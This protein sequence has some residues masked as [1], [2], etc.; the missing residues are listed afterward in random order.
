MRFFQKYRWLWLGL[1][2]L[3]GSFFSPFLPQA[4]QITNAIESWFVEDDPLL[5][6]YQDFQQSFG[7]DEVITVIIHD[8]AGVINRNTLL[9]MQESIG[10]MKEIEGVEEVY[11]LSNAHTFRLSAGRYFTPA[12]PEPLPKTS[13]FY[14]SL[15]NFYQ[16]A[17][18]VTGN[19]VH[20]KGRSLR[21]IVQLGFLS[22]IQ[23]RMDEIVEGVEKALFTHFPERNVS[24]GGSSVIYSGLNSLTQRDFALFLGSGVGLIMLF[25]LVLYR[26]F[27]VVIY[28]LATFFLVLWLA[29]GIY[30]ALGYSLNL[31]SSIAPI[32]LTIVSLLDII[33]ILNHY[34]AQGQKDIIPALKRVWWPCLFTTLTTVAGF[35]SFLFTPLSIL[36]QFGL[37]VGIGLSLALLVSFV[38]AFFFLP[39]ISYEKSSLGIRAE[40]LLLRLFRFSVKKKYAILAF[41]LMTVVGLGYGVSQ[42]NA[43][44]YTLGYFPKE[45]PVIEDHQEILQRWG[46]YFPID[47]M[48]Y[49]E[50]ATQGST[51]V[52]SP[53]LL[54][55]TAE[56]ARRV[57]DIEGITRASGFHELYTRTLPVM[58]GPMWRNRLNSRLV[59]RYT[60]QAL[61]RDSSLVR[62]WLPAGEKKGRLILSGDVVS[63]SELSVMLSQIHALSQEVYGSTADLRPTGYIPLYAGIV[64]Y[65][66]TSQQRSLAIAAGLVLVFLLLMLRGKV[67]LSLVAFLTNLLPVL[68]ILGVM[69]LAGI[70]LDIAT[71]LIAAV[72]L[73]ITIDDTIHFVYH[74]YLDRERLPHSKN[75]ERTIRQVGKAIL[76]TSLLLAG[77]F[78]LMV[79]ASAVPVRYFGILIA[80]AVSGALLSFTTFLPALM[81]ILFGGKR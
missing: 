13:Q 54:I 18:F 61:E 52:N 28:N 60:A 80:T 75:M 48:L 31:V 34:K 27:Y 29:L 22:D 56:F 43:N 33:H 53:E 16:S 77:G 64:G 26:D 45:H 9:A 38:L 15:A 69:G 81:D 71:S 8:T 24:M 41:Y 44:T 39:L 3:S 74:Y 25:L 79:F 57:T 23:H 68:L 2:M 65:V 47:M 78:G 66:V 50:D 46:Q 70:S 76:V 59:D 72:V 21:L 58:Y 5:R 40:N 6:T 14:D 73:G 19:F 12:L 10:E 67:L 42:M 32:L 20:K 30:G 4:L 7:S 36:R 55:K 62:R 63:T 11:S 17:P 37:L 49:P 1:L 51:V 35:A